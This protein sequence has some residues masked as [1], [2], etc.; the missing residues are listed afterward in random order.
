MNKNLDGTSSG[1]GKVL[2][3]ISLL[4]V[5]GAILALANGVHEIYATLS[6][7]GPSGQVSIDSVS[8]PVGET[9]IGISLGAVL[10]FVGAILAIMALFGYRFTPK[11]FVWTL[12]ILA[13][14]CSTRTK[15]FLS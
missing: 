13:V 8:G 6:T 11:W 7:I 10:G 2:A 1:P 12:L 14:L 3:I 5:L 4:F 9:M 15:L